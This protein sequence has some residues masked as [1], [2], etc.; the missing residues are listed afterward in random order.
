[1]PNNNIIIQGSARSKGNT[2]KISTI[3]Q[4]K[5][6]AEIIDLK[7]LTI[8]GYSYEHEYI[9]DDFL[10][11]MRKIVTYEKIIVV[12]PV[13]WYA[14]SGIMKNFFDRITDCLKIEKEL[15]RK[16]RKKQMAAVACGSDK[17]E[18]EGFFVPFQY[19]AEYLGMK[20][21]GD[22]HTWIDKEELEAEVLRR[23]E[24]FVQQIGGQ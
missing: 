16:L 22:V 3:L 5:L 23:I 14:M 13:Y 12:T 2:H 24:R 8:H 21:L 1:M 11:T 10:P 7:T 20:Y 18:T 17:I 15:G 19:S 4:Q 6:R 9:A